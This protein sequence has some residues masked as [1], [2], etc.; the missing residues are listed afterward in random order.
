[1]FNKSQNI[2]ILSM[3]PEVKGKYD[4]NEFDEKGDCGYVAL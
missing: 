2:N 1:M 3:L 4:V